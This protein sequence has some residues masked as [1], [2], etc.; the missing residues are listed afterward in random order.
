MIDVDRLAGAHRTADER[1]R[2]LLH[3]ASP[4]ELLSV[5]GRR[6]LVVR[7]RP[8]RFDDV[9][10][11]ED[12]EGILAYAPLQPGDVRVLGAPPDV[13]A[14]VR[15]LS[16]SGHG[17]STVA[18]DRAAVVDAIDA[19]LT[20]TVEA[21]DRFL[22]RVR[23]LCSAMQALLGG[24]A[25]MNAF[26]AGRDA[27][28]LGEHADGHDVF[29]LQL[30]GT[31]RWRLADVAIARANDDGMDPPHP[32]T[33]DVTSGDL[34]YVPRGHR[35]EVLS[36]APVS[37]HLSLGLAP[38]TLG[39]V[40]LSAIEQAMAAVPAASRRAAVPWTTTGPDRT[41]ITELANEAAM[42]VAHTKSDDVRALYDAQLDSV[43]AGRDGLLVGGFL[44]DRATLDAL[45]PETVLTLRT[46]LR[47]HAELDADRLVLR[48]HD[49]TIT[50]PAA[51][52]PWVRELLDCGRVRIGVLERWFTAEAA[53]KLAT[54]VV[55]AGLAT[56][57]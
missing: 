39:D 1:L 47:V 48:Y 53:R 26:I 50:L 40:A 35:H 45:R 34:L 49:R 42:A 12:V 44:R 33:I 38:L 23:E 17:T 57:Y 46:G 10:R 15:P 4:E 6:P 52:E 22:P 18:I 9:A 3:P 32:M 27:Q 36:T 54:A 2:S 16:Y 29:V 31:K 13:C 25:W 21:A 24:R 56:S 19:G 37:V 7:G 30:S 41:A 5:L 14:A 43:D 28:G 8:G 51:A 55:T 11:V 20:V